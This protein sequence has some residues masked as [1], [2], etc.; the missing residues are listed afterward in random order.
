MQLY[1]MRDFY[2]A[3]IKQI[4]SLISQTVLTETNMYVLMA[5]FVR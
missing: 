5:S 2:N 1:D 3:N 4:L